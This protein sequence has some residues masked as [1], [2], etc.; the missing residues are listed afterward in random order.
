VV[1]NRGPDWGLS[2][3][4]VFQ[5]KLQNNTICRGVESSSGTICSFQ[6]IR[7]YL[8]KPA[9]IC[10]L[11]PSTFRCCSH[12]FSCFQFDFGAKNWGNLRCLELLAPVVRV[13]SLVLKHLRC[14]RLRSVDR[15]KRLRL[16]AFHTS[17]RPMGENTINQA[18]RRINYTDETDIHDSFRMTELENY[19]SRRGYRNTLKRYNLEH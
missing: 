11:W 7:K 12:L 17:R 8:D 5:C 14:E 3:A 13:R 19:L 15:P 9:E 4:T 18:L 1:V 2:R 10:H 6:S 16:A